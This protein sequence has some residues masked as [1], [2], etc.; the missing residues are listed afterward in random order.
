MVVG[1]VERQ[2]KMK[3]V[4]IKVAWSKQ[5]GEGNLYK[6]VQNRIDF[7]DK[8]NGSG[9]VCLGTEISDCTE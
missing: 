5:N 4:L 1:K 2:S 6:I 7:V 3:G 8:L 9:C